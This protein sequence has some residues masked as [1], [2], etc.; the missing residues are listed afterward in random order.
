VSATSIANHDCETW[1]STGALQA[2]ADVADA[3]LFVGFDE[4]EGEVS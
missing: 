4:G 1:A 3:W 2:R